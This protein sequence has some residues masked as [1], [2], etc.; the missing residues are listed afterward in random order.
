MQH[1]AGLF[2]EEVL[3]IAEDVGDVDGKRG[4]YEDGDAGDA[5]VSHQLVQQE[6]DLLGAADG[7]G[8]GDDL[9]AA[10]G[11]AADDIGELIEDSTFVGMEAIAI[12][13]LH[14]E[15][16]AMGQGL[17]VANDGQMGTAHVAG[18]ADAGVAVVENDGD[19]AEH[20]AGFHG[21]EVESVAEIDAPVHGNGLEE[22]E[23]LLG[24]FD[25]VERFDEWL[26]PFREDAA[27]AVAAAV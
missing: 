19:T 9:A 1:G 18:E 2:V 12:G 11:G 20:V 7:E 24:V 13:G 23:G 16:V 5:S 27:A 21:F 6:N 26:V 17:G 3:V 22:F 10:G 14:D 25:R 4:V 15:V 8:G